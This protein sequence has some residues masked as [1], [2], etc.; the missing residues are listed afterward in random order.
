[1]DAERNNE[2]TESR[3]RRIIFTPTAWIKMTTLVAGIP[4]EVGWHGTVKREGD[5]FYITDILVYPQTVTSA[6]VDTSEEEYME[7]RDN[8]SDEQFNTLRFHGHSHVN[9]SPSP[10]PTDLHDQEEKISQLASVS[11]PER[12][13][14]IFMIINKSLE[15]SIMLYDNGE[16]SVYRPCDC[17]V[18]VESLDVYQYLQ[19][20]YEQNIS[21]PTDNGEYAYDSFYETLIEDFF[22][23]DLYGLK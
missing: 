9:F 12:N 6:H 16:R 11:D 18:S 14:Y 22:E 1:M 15:Y 21:A 10:S 7:W 2:K 4:T 13:Y 19:E 3:N 23:E 5:D 20:T 8:L 17:N